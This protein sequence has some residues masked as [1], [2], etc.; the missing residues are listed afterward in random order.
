MLIRRLSENG[1]TASVSCG[2]WA[3]LLKLRGSPREGLP[4]VKLTDTKVG[5]CAVNSVVADLSTSN[6]RRKHSELSLVN[7]GNVAGG[8]GPSETNNKDQVKQTNALN[9]GYN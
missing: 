4:T 8:V 3:A 9:T 5:L 6:N 2:L 1:W 7:V